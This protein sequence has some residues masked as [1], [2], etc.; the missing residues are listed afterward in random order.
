MPIKKILI[1]FPEIFKSTSLIKLY[2]FTMCTKLFVSIETNN[3]VS[4]LIY[5]V[6]G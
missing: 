4:V 5:L 3:I 6:I 2:A 1:S